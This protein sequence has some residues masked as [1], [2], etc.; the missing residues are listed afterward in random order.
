MPN[1]ESRIIKFPLDRSLGMTSLRDVENHGEWHKYA[2]AR[3]E[4]AVPSSRDVWLS[5]SYEAM[6]D[7]APLSSLCA[8]DLQVL[9]ITCTREFD[10]RELRHIENLTGLMGLALWE[11]ETRDAAF[12][13]LSGLANLHWLDIGD[14]QITDEGLAF[15]VGMSFPL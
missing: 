14:T 4:L 3:G 11:T 13:L 2:E 8:A 7:L 15:T 9:S 5:V 1:A 10:D 12:S 6:S